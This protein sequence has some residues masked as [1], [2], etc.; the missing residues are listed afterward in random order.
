MV[1][2]LAPNL[3]THRG[4]YALFWIDIVPLPRPLALV[5]VTGTELKGIESALKVVTHRLKS[6]LNR[7][8]NAKMIEST[9]FE[10]LNSLL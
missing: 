8:S 7:R 4:A 6:K 9:L 3:S 5:Y 1:L 2:L 10:T